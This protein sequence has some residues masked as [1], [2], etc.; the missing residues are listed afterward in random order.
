MALL[1]QT[2]L[3]TD[4]KRTAV[5]VAGMSTADILRENRDNSTVATDV[6]VIGGLAETG[7]TSRYQGFLAEGTVAAS[8]ATVNY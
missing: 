5:V 4:T 6:I 7:L 8:G 1:V 3:I 2:T